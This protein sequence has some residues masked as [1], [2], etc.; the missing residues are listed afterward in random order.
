MDTDEK[1]KAEKDGL[2]TDEHGC[3]PME[4]SAA[5]LFLSSVFICAPSVANS[6]SSSV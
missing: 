6:S 2:A 3:T 1:K 4:E 5:N